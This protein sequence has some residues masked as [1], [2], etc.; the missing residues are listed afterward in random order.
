MPSDLLDRMGKHLVQFSHGFVPARCMFQPLAQPGQR[1][2]QIMSD[3]VRDLPHA[4]HQILDAIEHRI[5]GFRKLVELVLR[6]A[7]RNALGKLSRHDR[8]R[9]AVHDINALQH[10]HADNHGAEGCQTIRS[11]RWPTQSPS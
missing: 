2:A 4:A 1:R 5:H 8:A 11:G 9:R 7:Y 10:R 3:I 6:P